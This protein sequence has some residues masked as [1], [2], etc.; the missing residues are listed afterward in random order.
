MYV[1]HRYQHVT[2]SLHYLP[3]CLRSTVSCSKTPATVI[4]SKPLQICCHVITTQ[5]RPTVEQSARDFRNP[6]LQAKEG[7]RVICK[8]ITA[9]HY[10]CE[11]DSCAVWVSYRK[12]LSV[13]ESNQLIGIKTPTSGFSR[14]VWFLIPISR[15]GQMPVL[16]PAKGRPCDHWLFHIRLHKQGQFI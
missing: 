7:T 2:A 1:A 9:G 3:R 5:L 6:P 12:K 14:N 10:D 8:L 16:P 11:P 4:Q 15:R 13:Q